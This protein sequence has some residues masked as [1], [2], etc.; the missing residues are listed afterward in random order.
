MKGRLF[1]KIFIAFLI[2]LNIQ[3]L[4]V[5]RFFVYYYPSVPSVPQEHYTRLHRGTL[6]LV[7]R[8]IEAGRIDSVDRTLIDGP[9]AP[10]SIQRLSPAALPSAADSSAAVDATAQ[11]E[12]LHSV[13]AR[14]PAGV[15]YRVALHA[16]PAAKSR[17]FSLDTRV[18][19]V[20]ASMICGL[21][22]ATGLAFYLARRI[23]LLSD[24][25]RAFAKGDLTTR[26]DDRGRDE[27]ADL[28]QDFNGMADR[29]E[30]L[31]RVRDQLIDDVSHELRSPLTRLQLAIAL[32]RQKSDRVPAALDR[33]EAEAKRLDE[34]VGELLTLSRLESDV[35]DPQGY[36]DLPELLRTIVADARF[37]GGEA[38]ILLAGVEDGDRPGAKGIRGDARLIGRAVEN[39]VRNAL[40]HSPPEG[41]IRVTLTHKG[42]ED[43]IMIEDE[44]P[45][46]PQ[47]QLKRMFEPFV[48]GE[49]GGY[50]LGLAI[51]RRAV[52][53]HRGRISAENRDPT[54]LC[55][56]ICLP[57]E[58]MFDTVEGER[59]AERDG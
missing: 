9:H 40:R 46:I 39:V 28:A 36:F 21:I 35:T 20:T 50:G 29:I 31:V 51:A 17:F 15:G 3:S 33:V 24:G 53:A 42:V 25:M 47:G 41:R 12:M 23:R 37:E 32:A 13:T 10:V 7:V 52:Q 30:Q 18:I 44:G 38:R 4:A 2:V 55:V 56:T 48:R 16:P 49:T 27:I 34:L 43:W 58:Q 19:S 45:G 1:W 54:G 8:A 22:F 57:C 14:D 26:L 5:T 11:G 59:E 6:H